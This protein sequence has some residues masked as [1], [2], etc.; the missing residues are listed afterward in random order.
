MQDSLPL[1]SQP[2]DKSRELI[3][4]SAPDRGIE[5]YV[6][7]ITIKRTNPSTRSKP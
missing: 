1:K 3:R 5:A 7:S 4:T 2:K 6:V